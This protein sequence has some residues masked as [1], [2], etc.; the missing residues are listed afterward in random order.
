MLLR[1][2]VS[3]ILVDLVSAQ[4][5][6]NEYASQISRKYKQYRNS[7]EN[8]LN[9]FDA[10]ASV[11]KEIDFDLKFGF[12]D[13]IDAGLGLDVEITWGNCRDIAEES[14][15]EAI[16]Q[17]QNFLSTE[18]IE[19]I[20]NLISPA[21]PQGRITLSAEA[22]ESDR[23]KDRREITEKWNKIHDNL[24]NEEYLESVTQMITQKLFKTCKSIFLRGR[25]SI[26]IETVKTIVQDKL[27]EGVLKHPDIQEA[28]QDTQERA[29]IYSSEANVPEY[30]QERAQEIFSN[31]AAQTKEREVRK[32]IQKL[33]GIVPHADIMITPSLLRELPIETLSSL[34]M[35]V[36]MDSYTWTI[37]ERGESLHKAKN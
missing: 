35:T 29:K 15:K 34:T 12:T 10:P 28:I 14:V 18:A 26:D 13:L 17:M 32:L 8:I 37:T 20:G 5:L 21:Q 24:D 19:A 1:K 27:Q 22:Q 7:K 11:L 16:K 31:T 4:D 23:D 6:S 33:P 9:N 25:E 30:V 2:V 36:K 3:A